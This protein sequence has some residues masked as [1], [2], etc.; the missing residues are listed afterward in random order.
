MVPESQSLAL[1]A[2]TGKALSFGSMTADM[3]HQIA[4]EVMDV[5]R[6]ALRDL[7]GDVRARV[8]HL[9]LAEKRF[10]FACLPD[11][12]DTRSSASCL[13]VESTAAKLS[14]NDAA[15][16]GSTAQQAKEPTAGGG[17]RAF[18]IAPVGTCAKSHVHKAP[19]D[20]VAGPI[21]EPKDRPRV[22]PDHG[23]VREGVVESSTPR[24]NGDSR[25]QPLRLLTMEE[26]PPVP[27]ASPVSALKGNREGQHAAGLGVRAHFA[28]DALAQESAI[29]QGPAPIASESVPAADDPTLRV[30]QS[31][32]N[33]SW[34][35][36][37]PEADSCVSINSRPSSD[38]SHRQV[39]KG[40]LRESA[41][42]NVS[43]GPPSTSARRSDRSL[44]RPF[45]QR[46]MHA[47]P[48]RIARTNSD[49]MIRYSSTET[50]LSGFRSVFRDITE[51][52]TVHSIGQR[53]ANGLLE[54]ALLTPPPGSPESA[55]ASSV[56]MNLRSLRRMHTSTRGLAGL[57]RCD[58]EEE[59]EDMSPPVQPS[60]SRTV[61]KEGAHAMGHRSSVK[62]MA[63][64]VHRQRS[65]VRHWTSRIR[66]SDPAHVQL[67]QLQMESN[68]EITRA[69]EQG[70]SPGHFEDASTPGTCPV[71]SLDLNHAHTEESSVCAPL[72]VRGLG[73]AGDGS[74][75]GHHDVA[76]AWR[77]HELRMA[78]RASSAPQ[79]SS[80]C[81][82]YFLV[83]LMRTRLLLIW[84]GAVGASIF[85][86]WYAV[87][88]YLGGK[89]AGYFPL[90]KLC[91]GALAL[92]SVI[93][94]WT[95]G[96]VRRAQLLGSKGLLGNYA[97][98]K[99]FTHSWQWQ[100]AQHGSCAILLWLVLIGTQAF[101][102]AMGD[103][104][105]EE[106]IKGADMWV[107]TC[108]S[109]AVASL[110]FLAIVTCL[111]H[112]ANAMV[113][114]VDRFAA[115]FVECPD[116]PKS[117]EDWNTLQA[118]LRR[119]SETVAPCFVVLH[120]TAIIVLMLAV[121]EVLLGG[122]LHFWAWLSAMLRMTFMVAFLGLLT[123]KA[124]EVSGKCDRVPALINSLQF[125]KAVDNGRQYLV[126]Y[127]QNSDAGF[128][129]FEEKIT[130]S[131]S[132]KFVYFV[133]LSTG[134]IITRVLSETSF[135]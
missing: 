15:A 72:W 76:L 70:A 10:P 99:G 98:I 8:L 28:A 50:A 133:F 111:L 110:I 124:A 122:P 4:D 128:H 79:L 43:P 75:S 29:R 2:H 38:G 35:M 86:T 69:V 101:C 97:K 104:R 91:D 13:S 106:E 67:S 93:A 20:G 7:H 100:S 130:L 48:P 135:P 66:M 90:H 53:V 120:T 40:T 112:V 12:E 113:L 107:G 87:S 125:G 30:T 46:S 9:Q 131:M 17:S 55:V 1:L 44:P 129:L 23:H 121:G 109:S 45:P 49:P 5:V 132:A 74:M 105:F 31:R 52:P 32:S 85:W 80:G 33:D 6:L 63:S 92:G 22:H 71:D 89:D 34:E 16:Q 96:R 83:M 127:M 36:R 78:L 64:G 21:F 60:R 73:L 11:D 41:A 39:A 123:V 61:S 65:S 117:L 95:V 81:W 118:I 58:D 57:G 62:S 115:L 3:A 51:H 119:A 102:T 84:L 88:E 82:G 37:L 27:L 14:V 103:K 94:L 24:I 59:E 116:I 77:H 114:M 134:T 26:A 126:Q 18:S 19:D 54:G 42:S 47:A 25:P 108:V 68:L 56:P